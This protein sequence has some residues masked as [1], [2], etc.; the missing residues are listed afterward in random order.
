V[1]V[2]G[3]DLDGH[4]FIDN[5][6]D[7]GARAVVRSDGATFESDP[8]VTTVLVPDSRRAAATVCANFYAHP[9]EKVKLIGVTGTNGKTTTTVL[10][11]SIFT[12]AGFSAGVI[13]TLSYR[14]PGK[15]TT[16]IQTTPGPP[17]LHKWLQMM[18]DHQV[19]YV[20]MEVSSHGLDQHRVD[21]CRF[22]AAVF[23]NLTSEHLDYHG[24]LE[25]YLGAK[26][27][28]FLPFPEGPHRSAPSFAIVNVDDR[29]GT[30]ICAK[31]PSQTLTYGLKSKAD[32]T[33]DRLRFTSQGLSA[34]VMTPWG[35]FPVHS[36]LIGEMNLYNILAATGAALTQEVPFEHIQR[37]INRVSIIPGRLEK[38]ENPLGA[39]IYVDYAHTPDALTRVLSTMKAL[40]PGRMITVFGCGGDRD[41]SKR[42]L[43]GKATAQLSHLFI[44]TSDNPRT[45][46]PNKIIEEIEAGAKQVT[47][48]E[49][50]SRDDVSP[51]PSPGYVIE[52]DRRQA[53]R[54]AICLARPGDT[55]LIAGKGHEDYQLIGGQRIHLDDREEARKAAH[56][57]ARKG[58]HANEA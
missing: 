9:S 24:N 8:P 21:Q 25:S 32:I 56:D 36:H 15:M 38:I 40:T 37:G 10:L 54:K 46:D 23:T 45:E 17:E 48:V 28:L 13:G 31:T 42:P 1:A 49:R 57:V 11:E 6:I 47:G 26:E 33:A 41:R 22:E 5:A 4:R 14:F 3:Q 29:A 30:H 18:V 39:A 43:M 58:G 55:V 20:A 34:T 12:E 53:I 16:A 52:P 19:T 50:F 44:I 35:S 2:K 7:S 27:K 51:I